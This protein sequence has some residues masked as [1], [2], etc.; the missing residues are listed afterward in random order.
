MDNISVVINYCS[1]EREYLNICLNQC[2]KFSND[3]V[4]SYGSH[5]YDG[6][7]EDHAHIEKEIA[8]NPEVKFVKYEVDKS[9]NL[10]LQRGVEKRPHAYWHNLARWTGL[11]GIKGEGWVLFLDVD[12]I[13]DGDRVN[14]WLHSF[15]LVKN[16]SYSLANYWYFKSPN[17]RAT[18]WESTSKVIYSKNIS[19]KSI[20][21]DAE[22]DHLQNTTGDYSEY[23]ILGLDGYPLIHHFSW[24][25]SEEVLLRK[26]KTW[27][28]SDQ[29]KDPVN[30]VKSIFENKNINDSVHN[31]KYDY[32]YNQFSI[33]INTVD[34]SFP[35]SF[36]EGDVLT[37][38]NKMHLESTKNS[39]AELMNSKGLQLLHQNEYA[40]AVEYFAKAIESSNQQVDYYNNLGIAI[41]ALG[42]FDSAVEIFQMSLSIDGENEEALYY[43]AK[44]LF[45]TGRNTEALKYFKQLNNT[46]IIRMES[47]YYLGCAYLNER[48]FKNALSQFNKIIV[49][50]EANEGV[51]K[52]KAICMKMIST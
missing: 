48:D 9:I 34:V 3:I 52:N 11:K 28:H 33:K 4:V 30:Y 42:N 23:G 47:A 41:H 7:I 38:K 6:T 35:L 26:I 27:G 31:Y 32:V 16:T 1:L 40:L 25:R 14:Q 22:R 20:F 45:K 18:E 29:V 50:G 15:N 36:K 21:G 10:N 44:S 5:F 19:E 39:S 43:L 13:P 37:L 12:E 49:N 17:Y 24:V 46:E 8:K 51:L 2:M